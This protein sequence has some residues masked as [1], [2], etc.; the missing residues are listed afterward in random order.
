M[1]TQLLFDYALFQCSKRGM[2]GEGS[3]VR[4]VSRV[5]WCSER[6]AKGELICG[7]CIILSH[8]HTKPVLYCKLRVG[9]R[10]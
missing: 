8:L 6:G 1:Y 7:L 10:L 3:P 4:S 2:L 5:H 9:K